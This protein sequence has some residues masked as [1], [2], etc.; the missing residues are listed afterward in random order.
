MA[1]VPENYA[2]KSRMIADQILGRLNGVRETGPGRWLARCPAHEDRSPSLSIRDADGKILLYCFAQCHVADV[3]AAVGL[4]LEDLFEP[5]PDAHANSRPRV[6]RIP[7]GD[8]LRALGGEIA[9]LIICASDLVK[10]EQLTPA[11]RERLCV[12]HA[13]F[14]AALLAGGIT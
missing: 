13:R 10:G 1:N 6:P 2:D 3:V 9:F 11:D 4:E 8:V 7:A 5:R 14:R 12:A